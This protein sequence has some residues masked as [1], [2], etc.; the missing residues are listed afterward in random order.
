MIVS[1][2]NEY[3]TRLAG[4][5]SVE[6]SPYGFSRQKI[7]FEVVIS[8]DGN[9]YTIHDARIKKGKSERPRLLIV[10][11][12]A[13]PPGA[14]INPCFMWDNSA[15]MLSYK[16]DDT[17]QDRTKE[18]FE[19]FRQ[20]H[21]DLEEEIND[22]HFSLVCKFL[23]AYTPDDTVRS[24]IDEIGSGFGV[25]RIEGSTDYVHDRKKI[26][27]WWA[28]NLSSDQEEA[29]LGQCLVTGKS[30][31]RLARIHEP[32]IKGVSGAQAA[33]ASIVSF[34]FDA[35]ESFD[36]EQG[37]NSPVSEEVA[38]QYSTALN[39]LLNS[40][41]RIRIGDATTVF[42]TDKASPAEDWLG[43]IIDTT[44][45]EDEPTKTKL[46]SILKTIA[47]G[48]FPTDFGDKDTEFY[49][50]GLSPNAARISIRF[51]LRSSLKQLVDSL[52]QH[53]VDL[54]ISHSE[55]D[56]PY[57]ALWQLLA[58]TAR[59]SKDISPQ[60]SG[61]LTRSVLTGQLYPQAFFAAVIRRI[62]AD[63]EIRHRRAAILKAFLNRNFR[64]HQPE[65]KEI[66]VA[67][68]PD[69]KEVA[70]QLGR[71][72]AQLEKAQEDAQPT[73]NDTIKDRFF[74]SASATPAS[75][76]PRIIRMSQHHLGKL[77]PGSKIYHEKSIQEIYSNVEDFP[78]HLNLHQQGL[79]SIGYY[80]QRQHIFTKK[81]KPS[82]AS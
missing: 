30:D 34:N 59:E 31:V 70:Y 38:F 27:S 4:D 73:V 20:R 49:V 61:S 71:L 72:F 78:N 46:G 17:N 75:V 41:Q 6:I 16:I 26:N 54:E 35:A 22:E 25:F 76:F 3:Y 74:G 58:E 79:F 51:W 45:A 2:L 80:H 40:K 50:L 12:G 36:K 14:G 62:K 55:N 11:G 43:R 23:S 47:Q 77:E 81:E 44:D 8:K 66:T 9:R 39:Y 15:Y 56:N 24:A 65:T 32:K 19:A 1:A 21:L 7:A 48:G 28:E 68:D 5:E 37:S 42:W 63:R 53:F 64:I 18:S 10:P 33:G 60:L 57:P 52:R 82:T 13:K 67:L 29:E 69:R